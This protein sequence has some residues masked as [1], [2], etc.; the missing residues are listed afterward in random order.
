MSKRPNRLLGWTTIGLL[1]LAAPAFAGHHEGGKDAKGKGADAAAR[2]EPS[3]ADRAKMADAHEKMA[4]CLRSSR[5]MKECRAEMRKA[6][7]GMH[8]KGGMHGDHDCGEH[9]SDGHGDA[10]GKHAGHGDGAGG[11]K[12]HMASDPAAN[13]AAKD[14]KDK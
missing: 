4:A 5:P 6:H 12:D 10:H 13:P 9:H 2:P 3:A 1:A 11:G 14:A 7:G 8:G